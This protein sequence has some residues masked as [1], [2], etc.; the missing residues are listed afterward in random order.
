VD[1]FPQ[2]IKYDW[3]FEMTDL[4]KEEFNISEYVLEYIESGYSPIPIPFKKKGPKL[5]KWPELRLNRQNYSSHFNGKKQNIGI[6]L[7]EASGGLI[8]I[9]LDCPEAIKLAPY[10]L[11]ETQ[12]VFGR[13]SRPRSH[14]IYICPEIKKTNKFALDPIG[15]IVEIR[16]NKMQ[17]VF[18]PSVHP[19][20]E[21]VT[22]Y[23]SEKPANIKKDVLVRAVSKLA[24]ASILANL[25]PNEGSRNEA[26]LALSGALCRGGFQK[27]E[28]EIFMKAVTQ[29]AED[30]ECENRIKIVNATY[31][32]YKN[33]KEIVGL[34]KLKEILGEKPINTFSKWLKLS[35]IADASGN[36]SNSRDSEDSCS[37]NPIQIT[38]NNILK[39]K[40]VGK[41]V[42]NVKLA[43]FSIIP[44]ES[45]ILPDKGEYL[46]VNLKSEKGVEKE[47]LLPPEVWTLKQTFLRT[48]PSKEFTWV[49]HGTNDL[50]W[51]RNKMTDYN[52]PQKLGTQTA[53]FHED[54]FI[55][56]DGSIGPNNQLVFVSEFKTRC[57]L[58]SQKPA[59]GPDLASI[60]NYIDKFNMPE[61]A[62]PILGWTVA[63]FLKD[64][65][66]NLLEH[67]P[68]LCLEGEAGSGKTST[69]EGILM[70][71][72]GLQGDPRTIS[73][74]SRFTLMKLA[75]SSNCIPIIFEENK[76]SRQNEKQKNQISNLIRGAYNGFEGDRGRQ[77]Q[78]LEV[79]NFQAPICIVGEAGFVEPAILDRIIPVHFSKK[80]SSQ[81]EENF[82][83]AQ[84]LN[85]KGLGRK[86]IDHILT[87][88]DN[89]L[90]NLIDQQSSLVDS[91]LKDRP[92]DNA[93]IVRVGLCILGNILGKSFDLEAVD[94]AIISSVL[95]ENGKGRK[96]L[97][98]TILE[99]FSRM[100]SFNSATNEE[101]P[102]ESELEQP[103]DL[104][105]FSETKKEYQFSE[106]LAEGIDYSIINGELRL[107]VHGIYPKFIAWAKKYSYDLELIPES[108]FKKQ[109]HDMPYFID[110]K[111]AKI[112][113]KTKNCYILDLNKMKETGLLLTETWESGIY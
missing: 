11:P 92:F 25:W 51:L 42:V 88:K 61:I 50:Q 19:S 100:S 35:S 32:K 104:K 82:K 89:Y 94:T 78:T 40:M 85:L 63:C 22:W 64:R 45:I 75:D 5:K 1:G 9:D 34:N 90:K 99:D 101:S 47:L 15:T 54:C 7:G 96:S 95:G 33:G 98:D 57:N 37:G 21:R 76:A 18:P 39:F 102:F 55:T 10:F 36:L 53:G 43:T 79:Y 48:L 13:T 112:G 3:D 46:K 41:N 26:A 12:A 29:V 93:L 56:E 62:L 111:Q 49:G 6:L 67:F 110:K 17:T 59:S 106:F 80:E 68:I 108:T 109:L 107:H 84:K 77:D 73:D 58:P 81:Y 8:D 72:W 87:A 2:T 71:I 31:E 16:S 30:E 97:V 24:S 38:E 105:Q 91:R 23:K 27:E 60:G 113:S 103:S 86:L 69:I 70:P 44:K 28:A 74:Q 65:F 14:W 66:M 20:G 4:D 52:I 83:K